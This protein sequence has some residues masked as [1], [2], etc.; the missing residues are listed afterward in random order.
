MFFHKN[1]APLTTF[2]RD[3]VGI[4]KTDIQSN[5]LGLSKNTKIYPLGTEEVVFLKN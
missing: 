3:P 4:F 1:R 5:K 2:F